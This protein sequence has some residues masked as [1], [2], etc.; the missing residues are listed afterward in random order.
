MA[1]EKVKVKVG[2]Y[3][4][5]CCEGCTIVFVEMLNR[6]FDEYVKKIDFVDFR[7]LKPSKG[8]GKTD[9]AFVEG[10]ISTYDQI[11]RLKEIRKKTKKLV[12]MGAA[13]MAG[14]PS[15]HRNRFDAEKLKE[16]MHIVKKLNQVDKVMPLKEYVKVDDEIPGC[17]I[18]EEVLIKKIDS[19][20]K[21]A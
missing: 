7:A 6:K 16:I 18:Q 2:V 10:A 5:T 3:S 8:I 19:Y 4:F 11:D 9:I 15:D 21:N 13:A 1:K 12:A 14:Y 20:L 17:P